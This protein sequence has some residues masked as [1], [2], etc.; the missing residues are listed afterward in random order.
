MAGLRV[1]VADRSG[2]VATCSL[3]KVIPPPEVANSWI[4]CPKTV[5]YP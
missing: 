2:L 5:F 3:V 1:V 4:T